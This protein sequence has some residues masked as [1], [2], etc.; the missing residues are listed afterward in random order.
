MSDQNGEMPLW[1]MRMQQPKRS[2]AL[3]AHFTALTGYRRSAQDHNSEVS[4]SGLLPD[5]AHGV[6]T[7]HKSEIVEDMFHRW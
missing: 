1:N 2:V 5:V 4:L 6:H 3:L 7:P